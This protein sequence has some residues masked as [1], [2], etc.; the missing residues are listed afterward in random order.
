MQRKSW[1]IVVRLTFLLLER[2]KVLLHFGAVDWKTDVWVND[3]KVGSHTGGFTPF[4]FDITE[5]LQ[6]KNNTLLVKV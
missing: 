1:S 4:S 2:E 6:G 5:A 3:V